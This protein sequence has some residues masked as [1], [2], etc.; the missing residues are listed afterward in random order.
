M[1]SPAIRCAYMVLPWPLVDAFEKRY[2]YFNAMIP[3]YHERAIAEMIDSGALERHLR[4][5]SIIDEGKY[6][7]LSSALKDYLSDYVDVLGAPAGVHTMVRVRGCTNQKDLLDFLEKRSIRIYGI[8]EHCH[9]Q[10]NAYENVFLMGY[11]SMSPEKLRKG[12]QAL[13]KALK[14]YFA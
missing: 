12:C 13:A 1:L 8:K 5:I 7:A 14:E 4:N 3:A 2:Q 6:E 10:I 9:D 11:N